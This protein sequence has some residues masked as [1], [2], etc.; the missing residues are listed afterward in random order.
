LFFSLFAFYNDFETFNTKINY[1]IYKIFLQATKIYPELQ[2]KK[3]TGQ[4]EKEQKEIQNSNPK[5]I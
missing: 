4:K 2:I 3:V 5:K 1:H